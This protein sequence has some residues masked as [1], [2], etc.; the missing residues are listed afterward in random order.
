MTDA[1]NAVLAWNNRADSGT[2]TGGGAVATLPVQNM[3]DPQPRKVYRTVGTSAYIVI[4]LLSSLACDLLALFGTN[5]TTGASGLR[6]RAS[7]TDPAATSSL[8]Y[9]SNSDGGLVRLGPDERYGGG[10][11]FLF[12]STATA[13]YWRVD[14][15]DASLSVVD[16]GRL[17]LG[18]KFV[19]S[20]SNVS[21]GYGIG[22]NSS[23]Q[24]QR[25]VGGPIHTKHGVQW[26]ESMLTIGFLT[27]AEVFEGLAEMQ[28]LVGFSKD[29]VFIENPIATYA[30]ARVILAVR[31]GSFQP[32]VNDYFQ[33]YQVQQK[34]LERL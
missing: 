12:G 29:V 28:R 20:Q 30:A 27:E 3:Q 5:L 9:D 2:V 31:E 1:F 21:Y 25:A 8:V 7:I 11:V 24:N 23:G 6:V 18:P 26:R 22:W 14:V 34:L 32:F 13:R 15:A 17:I 33:L 10:V 4:D 19:P 16:I